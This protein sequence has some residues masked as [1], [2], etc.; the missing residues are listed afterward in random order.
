L[1]EPQ[2]IPPLFD[3]IESAPSACAKFSAAKSLLVLSEES[4]A[5]VY[6]YFDSLAALLTHENSFEQDAEKVVWYVIRSEARI[7]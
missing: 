7:L 6:P 3:T 1:G 5:T 4:P 2:L